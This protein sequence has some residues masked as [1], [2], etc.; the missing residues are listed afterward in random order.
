MKGNH[1]GVPLQ[2]PRMM[3]VIAVLAVALVGTSSVA[4]A[5]SEPQIHHGQDEAQAQTLRG[6]EEQRLRA[7]VDADIRTARR[8]HAHDFQLINPAGLALSDEEYLAFVATGAV[9]YLVFEPISEIVVRTYGQSGVLR[10]QSQIEVVVFG[11]HQSLKAWHTDVYELRHG[12]W[13]VVWSQAT[14]IQ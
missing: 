13:Q 11:E 4:V 9:D 14:A 8:L 2:Y 5:R 7:L 10:Y 6:I 3:T 12:R 1:S